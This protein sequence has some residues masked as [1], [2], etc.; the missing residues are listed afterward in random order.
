MRVVAGTAKGRRLMGTISPQARPTTERVRAAIFNIISPDLYHEGRVLDLYAG[1]GSLGI[2][3]LSRGAS[4]ADFVEQDR[5]QCG[6]IQTNLDN[7]G[8]G[9]RGRVHCALV[10]GSL[11][12]LAGPYQLVLLDPPYRLQT[13]GEVLEKIGSA[14][15][16]VNQGGMVVAG[17]SRHLAL[18]PD[19]GQLRLVS[20]RRYGDNLVDFYLLEI[21]NGD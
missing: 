8:F 5:R 10:E 4:W 7:T 14:Q 16:L 19:Y 20:N 6:V 13:L 3:A 18:L 17:H 9:S 1:S 2:E 12:N 11:D 15:G 21:E